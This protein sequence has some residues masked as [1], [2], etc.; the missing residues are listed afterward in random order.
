MNYQISNAGRD[1]TAHIGALEIGAI[2]GFDDGALEAT[3]YAGPSTHLRR[4][5]VCLNID[6]RALEA[7]IQAGPSP[8][9]PGYPGCRFRIEDGEL[10]ATV[11]VGPGPNGLTRFPVCMPRID[12]GALEAAV[13][14]GPQTMPPMCR[15]ID[16]SA[17][18][19]SIHAGPPMTM[20]PQCVFRIDDGALETAIEA[21]PNAQVTLL[22]NS[23]R[24]CE[25]VDVADHALEASALSMGPPPAPTMN[26]QCLTRVSCGRIDD[27]ALE[28][29]ALSMD[30]MRTVD[31]RCRTRIDD[32]ALD[33]TVQVGPSTMPPACRFIDDS[34]LEATVQAGPQ[35]PT[36]IR[37]PGGGCLPGADDSAL[38]ATVQAGPSTMPPACR[39]RIDA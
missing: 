27:D 15:F 23:R 3:V 6:D 19:A 36:A 26:L 35:R 5:T 25:F 30:P 17:L 37:L 11:Q 21:G 31:L 10:E 16:D 4:S 9:M 14:A 13:Q 38:E 29:S 8:T 32:G 20:P 12:D 1:I 28:A 34:V 33:A 39:F 18:E 24:G 22:R 7:S 2:N